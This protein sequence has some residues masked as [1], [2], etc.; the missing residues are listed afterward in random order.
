MPQITDTEWIEQVNDAYKDYGSILALSRSPLA[1]SPLVTPALVL[2]PLTPTPEER[3]RGLQLALR[4]ALA[5]IA[6]EPPRYPLGEFRP[7]DDPTWRD[8]AWWRY[9]ILR[10][11]YVEPLHPDD[12]VES[13]RYTETLMALTGIVTADAFFD[14]RNRAVRAAAAA[15]EQL[16]TN[17][18]AQDELQQQA[19]IY[20][21]APL[22]RQPELRAMLGI[23]AAL[24]GVFPRTLLLALA[25][26][27]NLPAPDAGVDALILQR[28]ILT[29][30]AGASL[31]MAPALRAYIYHR[32]DQA[33]RR[34]RHARVAD[35]F[36]RRE[37]SLAAAQHLRLAEQWEAAADQLLDHASHLTGETPPATLRAEVTALLAGRLDDTRRYRLQVWASDL[38]AAMGDAEAASDACRAALKVAHTA[39]EQ[40]AVFRRMGKLYEMRNQ[41]R[42]LAYYRQAEAALSQDSS[43]ELVALLKDRG[44]LHIHRRAWGEAAADLTR[45]LSLTPVNDIA[46]RADVLDALAALRRYQHD[47]PAAISYAQQALA[48]REQSGDLLRVTKSLGNLGLLYT[49]TGEYGHAVAAH[50]EARAAAQ[51]L[52]SLELAATATLNIGLAHH[53]AGD[54]VKAVEVYRASLAQAREINYVLVELRALSNLAEALAELGE[55]EA[56]Q[57]YWQRGVELARREEFDDERAYLQELAERFGFRKTDAHQTSTAPDAGKPAPTSAGYQPAVDLLSAEDAL[58]LDLAR[59][60]GK[61]TPRRLMEVAHL[62][63][64]TATRRLTALAAAGLLTQVGRGRGTSYV[65]DGGRDWL[66]KRLESGDWDEQGETRIDNDKLRSPSRQSPIAQTHSP[67]ISLPHT[68]CARYGILA[69]GRVVDAPIL[70]LRFE[71]LPDLLT[72]LALRAEVW[73]EV[74]E[75]VE[76]LPVEALA[77]GQVVAWQEEDA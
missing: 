13:G 60:E 18:R 48:L 76:M 34:V 28:F 57:R 8:P 69:V 16:L 27:E 2:D 9:N 73:Q 26:A 41:L 6:P 29:G 53:L 44:W 24:D 74:G 4:W 14:V 55:L 66:N 23:A 64:A 51:R 43:P 54:R 40:G 21:C 72:F 67:P 1:S 47:L 59:R 36:A 75:T 63:K 15:L 32:E 56:A 10:H 49:A 70:A 20:F 45:A 11:R 22:M 52:G 39:S 68:L 5:Q 33:R 65:M 30:D 46:T 35:Y 77:P 7:L 37:L 25:S 12:F 3:G 19:L 31:W 71:R 61:V 38:S 17:S 58:A 62:S 50:Q 42:A